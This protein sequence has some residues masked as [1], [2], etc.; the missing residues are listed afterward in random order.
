MGEPLSTLSDCI[1]T[2][3]FQPRESTTE[4]GDLLAHVRQWLQSFPTATT[5]QQCHQNLQEL[6][7]DITEKH[8]MFLEDFER[9]MQSMAS[10]D[11][12]WRFCM[13]AICIGRLLGIP[14]SLSGHQN[15]ELGFE[16]GSIN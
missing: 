6:L 10:R 9:F 1:P 15:R 11:Q 14:R 5:Q 8:P 7:S 4:D 13:A 16:D 3:H 2:E 12:S